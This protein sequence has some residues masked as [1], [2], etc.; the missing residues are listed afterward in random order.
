MTNIYIDNIHEFIA[1][2]NL[3]KAYQ[4]YVNDILF[5]G[6][7]LIVSHDGSN[8]LCISSRYNFE[9]RGKISMDDVNSMLFVRFDTK[10]KDAVVYKK[11]EV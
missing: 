2:F 10:D 9:I 6:V 3:S 8:T 7:T 5:E 4:I 1:E 11:K